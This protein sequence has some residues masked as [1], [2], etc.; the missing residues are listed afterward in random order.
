MSKE[1]SF[2]LN[3]VNAPQTFNLFEKDG[4]L[5]TINIRYYE[6]YHT[7]QHFL[8]LRKDLFEKFIIGNDY[9]L[10]WGIWGE[11]RLY[12]KEYGASRDFGL[13]NKTEVYKVFKEIESY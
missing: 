2:Q 9:K 7:N 5:A 6:D 8:Y 12:F 10:I 1:I 13:K 3:L 4:K 11:K